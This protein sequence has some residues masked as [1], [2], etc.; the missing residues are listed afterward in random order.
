MTEVAWAKLRVSR[1]PALLQPARQALA[2]RRVVFSGAVW[3]VSRRSPTARALRRLSYA[4]GVAARPVPGS[5]LR[6]D[7]S[8]AAAIMTIAT[9]VAAP[10]ADRFDVRPRFRQRYWFRGSRLSRQSLR[11]GSGRLRRHG[12]PRRRWRVGSVLWTSNCRCLRP[13]LVVFL[14]ILQRINL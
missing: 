11:D 10:V 9:L 12:V 3:S 13:G 1:R 5:S 2:L 4:C 6:A 8:S 14:L 7:V